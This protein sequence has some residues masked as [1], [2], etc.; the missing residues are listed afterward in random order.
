M[1]AVLELN[2]I[3]VASVSVTAPAPPPAPALTIDEKIR[4][5]IDGGADIAT[6]TAA[7]LKLRDAKKD[8]DA[9]LKAKTA[10]LI[11][12]MDA[13]ETHFLAKFQEMGVDSVKTPNGTPYTSNV[14][15]VTVADNSAFLDFVLSR[16]LSG[17]PLTD[18]AKETIKTAMLDSGALSLVEARAAKSAVEEYLTE[19][20]EL[21]PG[22]NRRVETRLNIRAS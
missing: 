18:T 4:A 3:P 8:L 14:S 15:S 22:L 2:P 11:L 6:L 19:T 10:P 21:P 5:M 1:S 13:I 7:Y 17:L 20:Q 9:Q 16:A 12:A